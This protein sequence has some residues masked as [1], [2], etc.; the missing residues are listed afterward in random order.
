MLIK[1][2]GVGAM[3]MERPEAV[4]YLGVE[5]SRTGVAKLYGVRVERF[6]PRNEILELHLKR[7]YP[8]E[9][10][11]L[12]LVL[13]SV[14][15]GFMGLQL[16]DFF[17]WLLRGGTQYVENVLVLF[18]LACA[19]GWLLWDATRAQWY[20]EVKTQDRTRKLAFERKIDAAVLTVFLNYARQLGYS[21]DSSVFE[22]RKKE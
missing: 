1:L 22:N 21:V 19:G 4:N 8:G 7:G 3:N 20:L 18:M 13:G 16:V 11:L 2:A 6:I 12:Q 10:R 9:R 14:L 15:L 17:I 5:V